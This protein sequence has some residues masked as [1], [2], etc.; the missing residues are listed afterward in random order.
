[1]ASDG[2]TRFRLLLH[3]DGS[4][5]H[6][7]Q[8][9][10]VDPTVQ[11]ELEA[12]LTRL[13]GARRV[14]VGAG[15]TDRG[16]HATGQVAA[17][18]VPSRWDAPSLRKALNAVLPRDIWVAHL[19]EAGPRFHPRYDALERH[20]LYRVGVADVSGS[21]FHRPW[22]WPLQRPLDLQRLR[23]AAA[24]L[25]G[26]HSFRRFAR[27]GQE[28]RGDRCRVLYAEWESWDELGFGFRIGANRFLHHMVRYL[29]GTMVA[30]GLGERPV[31]DIARLLEDEPGLRT[32]P[33]APA[34]GLFLTGV[35]YP[36]QALDPG[37]PSA[38]G[39][40]FSVTADRDESR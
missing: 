26:E 23:E 37:V 1:M 21:P 13:T 19:Q 17:V 32:S 10:P 30:I 2:L 28:E 7:W 6:G 31:E 22:C 15:R 34:A 27:S 12:A 9:Q 5:Y 38:S 40:P 39:E 29:V 18:D 20:Y 14:V 16:V 8:M 35:E 36:S 3:Y 4:R 33:P 11:G 25:P 24:L